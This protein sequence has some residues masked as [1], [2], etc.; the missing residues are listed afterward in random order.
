MAKFLRQRGAFR[1][2]QVGLNTRNHQRST[3]FEKLKTYAGLEIVETQVIFSHVSKGSSPEYVCIY[4][5]SANFQGFWNTSSANVPFLVNFKIQHMLLSN[6]LFV[7][8][9]TELFCDWSPSGQVLK[10]VFHFKIRNQSQSSG[11]KRE[12]DHVTPATPE[13]EPCLDQ[14]R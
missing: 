12:G 9:C 2:Q 13:I 14:G 4:F 7:V 1:D 10:R 8:T 5:N 3:V 6:S 11:S